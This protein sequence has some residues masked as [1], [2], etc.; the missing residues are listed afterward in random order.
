[1]MELLRQWMKLL[2]FLK[3]RRRRQRV[4]MPEDRRMCFLGDAQQLLHPEGRTGP[5]ATVHHL[6]SLSGVSLSWSGFLTYDSCSHSWQ[7]PAVLCPASDKANVLKS[8]VDD[9]S[10]G[11]WLGAIT[12]STPT[13]PFSSLE[14]TVD[15]WCRREFSSRAMFG[16]FRAPR[17]QERVIAAIHWLKASD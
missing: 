13:Q 7:D 3:R 9:G 16:C 12:P 2:E 14:S 1:M 6:M 10:Q 11:K 4:M 17:F 15:D 8:V 5:A